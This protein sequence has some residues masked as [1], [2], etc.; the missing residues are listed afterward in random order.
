MLAPGAMASTSVRANASGREAVVWFLDA[1]R[2]GQVL[3]RLG[4]YCGVGGLL[5]EASA[6]AT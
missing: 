3:A 6:H 1:D 5:R 2:G 4:G